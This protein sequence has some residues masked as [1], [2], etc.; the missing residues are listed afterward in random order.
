MPA[1]FD[2]DAYAGLRHMVLRGQIL[3]DTGLIAAPFIVGFAAERVMLA[4]LL[5]S[6]IELFDRVG[7]HDAFY[8]VLADVLRCPLLTTDGSLVRAVRHRI[9]IIAPSTADLV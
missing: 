8:V 6:A 4:P 1:H 2:A 9:T 5:A 7:A 3:R